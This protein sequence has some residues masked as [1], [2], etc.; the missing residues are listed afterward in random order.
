M[1]S[2]ICS[3]RLLVGVVL[4]LSG[5]PHAFLAAQ[6]SSGP[7][8]TLSP[9]SNIQSAVDQS[10][11]NTTF[12]LLAGTYRL[13]SVAPKNGDAFVGAGAV[14]LN[15]S[16]VLS[17]QADSKG[18]G[19]WVADA[20][21]IP[22]PM[23]PCDDT[24]PLCGNIQ[25]LFIDSVLQTPATALQGLKPGF[26]YL[27]R[28]K[29]KAYL[30]GDP[31]GHLIEMGMKSYAFYGSAKGV[32][33]SRVIVEKYA[34]IAQQG[35]IGDI[36]EGMGWIVDAVEARWNH[37]AGVELGDGSTLS[38]SFI[39]HN[40]QLGIALGG[41]NC[42]AIANEIAWNNY[43]GYL[44][45]WEAGGS[46]FWA[47]TNLVVQQNYVHDNR[48]PGLWTDFNNVGTLYEKNIV[49]N[50]LNEGIKHEISFSATIRYNTVKGNG[51]TPTIWGN[52][53]QIELQ[54]SSGSVIYGNTVEV[55]AT[56]G[57]GI[58]LM[59]Q[60]RC[61]STLGAWVAANDSVH[62]NTITYLGG[63]GWSGIVD[64][65]T[66]GKAVG[67]LFDAN[68]YILPANPG[69]RSYWVWFSYMTWEGLKAAGEEATG[70]CCN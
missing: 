41:V 62:D 43:A 23:G 20:Q 8:M 63:N 2:S 12:T 26:W 18:S 44:P 64:D 45:S 46:K 48:G 69:S 56:N 1:K 10:P 15:G 49:I 38:N 54:N 42:K 58:V 33:I 60:I 32:K 39:H 21:A 51:N 34:S 65:T 47:T 37:G 66:G 52:N 19:F 57:N 7:Q 27:D 40:G 17:F 5:T 59:N 29:N 11:E 30:P 68:R 3:K 50:N 25:D 16:T 31:S 14:I 55:P 24:H 53:A 28:D 6:S 35:A 9:G 70:K 36:K 22:Q 61:C 13:Q 67:N 4:C